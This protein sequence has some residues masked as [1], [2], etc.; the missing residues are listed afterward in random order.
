MKERIIKFIIIVLT[1]IAA[2]ITWNGGDEGLVIFVIIMWLGV[3]MMDY[4]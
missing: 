3:S 1:A 2:M 4:D